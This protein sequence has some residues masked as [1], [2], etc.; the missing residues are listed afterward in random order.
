MLII[1][2][3]VLMVIYDIICRYLL[4]ASNDWAYEATWMF[5]AAFWVLGGAYTLVEE[6]HISVD[7]LFL[8]FPR[9]T[10]YL[11]K[12]I[13]MLVLLLPFVFFVL[14]YGIPW[15]LHSTLIREVSEHTLW[16]PYVFPIKWAL[17]IGFFFLGLQGVSTLIRNLLRA[18]KGKDS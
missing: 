3:M 13:F 7:I 5:Y 10:Q 18:I 6:G 11:L 8:R 16:R 1:I 14:K 17:V 12:G 2:P 15:V 4:Q 9:R